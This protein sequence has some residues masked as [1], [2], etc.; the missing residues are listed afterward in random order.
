MAAYAGIVDRRDKNI[1]RLLDRLRKRRVKETTMV[2]FFSH[3]GGDYGNGNIRIHQPEVSWE[4][5]SVAPAY[6]FHLKMIHASFSCGSVCFCTGS[7][8]G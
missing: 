4:R 2:L 3:N 5:A 6:P 8:V 1:D 7:A